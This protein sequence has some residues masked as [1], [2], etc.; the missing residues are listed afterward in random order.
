MD[1][2]SVSKAESVC[3]QWVALLGEGWGLDL[4]VTICTEQL[5]LNPSSKVMDAFLQMP[6][7]VQVGV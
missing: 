2:G 6:K 1:S 7:W 5:G 4:E 3:P